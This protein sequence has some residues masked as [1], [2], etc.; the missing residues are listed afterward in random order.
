MLHQRPQWLWVRWWA[1]ALVV[2]ALVLQGTLPHAQEL[3]VQIT[4]RA[5][6]GAERKHGPGARLRLVSWVRLMA[7]NGGKTETEKLQIVNQFFNQ[8]PWVSD[9]D[10]WGKKDYWATPSEMLATN[11]GDCEDYSI[12]KYFTLIALGV[13]IDRLK[14]TYVKARDPNPINQAHM[15]LTYYPTPDAVPL[16]LDNLIPEIRPA[17]QRPDLTPVY[18]FNGDGLWVAK[19]RSMGRVA[20][21]PG[22]IS[23]WR[24]MMARIGK[25][26]E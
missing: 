23:L 3:A 2:V 26:F 18:A 10:H 9:P 20:S 4:E 16:V 13:P 19:E 5:L 8:I 21:G 24:D 25:E 14:I 11:G 22:N 6:A 15:V 7:E 17:T 1:A 12:G